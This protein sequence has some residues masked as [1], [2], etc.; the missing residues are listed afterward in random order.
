MFDVTTYILAR[1]FA[2]LL[3]NERAGTI[4]TVESASGHL[5]EESLK[6]LLQ[7]DAST[8]KYGN[9]VYRLS[10]IEGNN[11]KYVNTRSNGAADVVSISEIDVDIETGDFSLRPLIIDS[12]PVDE[13]REEFEAH[14]DNTDIHTTAEE[15]EIWNNKVSASAEV[16][17]GQE[18]EFKLL[19]QRS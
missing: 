7:S 8:L 9:K 17:P 3:V 16:V 4:V 13:L 12:T 1:Q 19:L 6:N 10:R 18:R 14:R 11:Y 15:K 2:T 5:D